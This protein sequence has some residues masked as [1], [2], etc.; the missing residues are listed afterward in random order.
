MKKSK[1]IIIIGVI[2]AL[3]YAALHFYNQGQLQPVSKVE[4]FVS[5]EVKNESADKLSQRLFDQKLIKNKDLF[6]TYV[7]SLNRVIVPKNYYLSASMNSIDIAATVTGESVSN[8]NKTINIKYNDTLK[9]IQMDL[10][11]QLKRND[12][13]LLKLAKNADFIK[14]N[15][16]KFGFINLTK[17]LNPEIDYYL[18]GYLI[19]GQYKI[20]MTQNYEEI[21]VNLL[22]KTQSIYQKYYKKMQ[23]KH[24]SMNGL[25]SMASC[26]SAEAG[27]YTQQYKD[28][29]GV[30]WN[31]IN[32]PMPLQLDATFI[33]GYNHGLKTR[34][35]AKNISISQMQ[36]EDVSLYNTYNKKGLPVGPITS[37]NEKHI[38]AVLNPSKHDYLFYYHYTDSDGQRKV[39]F[40]KTY[41]QHL[42]N[43]KE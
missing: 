20:N 5:F 38:E 18:E 3:I 34:D 15:Q 36:K 14:L 24:L 2:F 4:N 41:E 11:S 8:Y 22:K 23:E 35:N 9:K 17:M 26:L 10:N 25:L 42:K 1:I 33:Y 19:S 6:T 12:Q 7:K 13:N 21:V 39:K 37:V 30:F 32:K 43:I 16:T 29:A 28:I 27:V 31:R 40:A